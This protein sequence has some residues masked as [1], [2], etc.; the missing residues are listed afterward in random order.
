MAKACEL[1]G[2][3]GQF[4]E[5]PLSL[6][7][8]FRCGR[9][10]HTMSMD[11]CVRRKQNAAVPVPQQCDLTGTMPRNVNRCKVAV[12]RK[13]VAVFNQVIDRSSLDDTDPSSKQAREYPVSE[14]G[15]GRDF[16]KSSAGFDDGCVVYVC[17]YFCAS[18]LLQGSRTPDVIW[19]GMGQ[20][21]V[22]HLTRR[23]A[24]R[25]DALQDLLR[26]FGEAGVNQ[27]VPVG[28]RQ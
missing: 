6:L 17:I 23:D 25:L 26:S 4:C 28:F 9:Q 12:E 21:N 11:A 27:D 19:M 1:E 24:Y 7:N 13:T 8:V 2:Q 15:R 14:S 16:P 3:A 5:T 10:L 20:N 22:T 18:G